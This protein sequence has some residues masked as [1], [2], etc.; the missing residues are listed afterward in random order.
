MSTRNIRPGCNRIRRTTVAG[1]RSNTPASDAITT[2]PS[3][4]TQIREGRKP[5]RSST[6]PITVPS[7]KVIDAG[8]SQGSINEAWYW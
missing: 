7:V 3:S 6:A 5:F 8:P 4:V 1:S 2:K